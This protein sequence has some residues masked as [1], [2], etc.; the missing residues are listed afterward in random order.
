MAPTHCAAPGVAHVRSEVDGRPVVHLVVLPNGPFVELAGAAAQ[1]W[2]AALTAG[3]TDLVTT[4]AA[5]VGVPPETIEDQ[6]L[7]F[8]AELCDRGLLVTADVVTLD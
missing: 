8:V 5:A 6:V 3:T 1:I 2:D 7:E 4:V